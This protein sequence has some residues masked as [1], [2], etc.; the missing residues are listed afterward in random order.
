MYLYIYVCVNRDRRIQIEMAID[1]DTNSTNGMSHVI[2]VAPEAHFKAS[3]FRL[4]S[5]QEGPHYVNGLWAPF[6]SFGRCVLHTFEIQ[7][8]G[9]RIRGPII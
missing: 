6:K 3:L 4:F 1:I 7:L 9:S 2:L 5:H 8:G